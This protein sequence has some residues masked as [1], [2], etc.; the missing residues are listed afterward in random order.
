MNISS[1][2]LSTVAYSDIFDYPL[3]VREVWRFLIGD[4]GVTVEVVREQLAISTDYQRLPAG[5]AGIYTDGEFYFLRGREEI[6]KLR[7]ER[8]KWSKEKWEIAQNTAK[9]LKVIPF[10]KMIGVTGALAMNNCK[11]NDDIDLIIISAAN[12]LWLTRFLMILF[13]PILGIKRRKRKEVFVKDKICF[14]LF[15]EENHLKIEPENLF[16]AHEI[17]QVKPVYDRGGIYEKFMRENKWIKKYLPNA[18][19]INKITIEQDNNLT[20]KGGIA[21]LLSCH[22]DFMEKVAF[23]LQFW[24]MKSK[25]T[26]E[27]VSLHQAFF[28]PGDLSDKVQKEFR[29]RLLRFQSL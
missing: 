19:Q 22:L 25:M 2:V 1:S 3:T 16:L 24:Y 23:R 26:C 14:N 10:I 8:G 29:R 15:L 21:I 11:E 6:V 9:K 7:K 13:C 12:S 4:S 27:K 20:K 5:K 17:C 28:H 18:S